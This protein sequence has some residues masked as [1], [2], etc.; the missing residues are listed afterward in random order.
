MADPVVTQH[1]ET[2]WEITYRDDQRAATL[3]L[4]KN[5]NLSVDFDNG[6][7]FRF[8]INQLNRIAQCLGPVLSFLQANYPEVLV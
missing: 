3:Y 6:P 2:I 4:D 1:T 7:S 8:H 5:R